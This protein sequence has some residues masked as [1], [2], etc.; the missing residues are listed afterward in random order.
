MATRDLACQPLEVLLVGRLDP[1]SNGLF[2]FRGVERLLPA[3]T[4]LLAVA[5]KRDAQKKVVVL[6]HVFDLNSIRRIDRPEDILVRIG[7][8]IRS[9]HHELPASSGAKLED[10]ERAGEALWSPPPGQPFRL[11]EGSEHLRRS[12]VDQLRVDESAIVDVFC[13]HDGS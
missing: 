5:H 2:V 3:D 13:L 8:A 6:R 12:G 11:R 1:L 7:R 9:V 10:F 4:C